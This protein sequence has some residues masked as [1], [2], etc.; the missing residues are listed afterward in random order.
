[1]KIVFENDSMAVIDGCMGLG[2]T[3][4][5]QAVEI[6]IAKALASGVAVVALRNAGHIGRV[7][8]WSEMAPRR[9]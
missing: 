2:Q 6:G 4:T 8:D 7:G 5:P 9:G 3:V 1:V